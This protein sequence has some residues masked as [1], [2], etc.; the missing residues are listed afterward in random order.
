[1]KLLKENFG[2]ES[3]IGLKDWTF[4]KRIWQSGLLALGIH[5]MKL[6]C[7]ST[8]L[9]D[10]IRSTYNRYFFCEGQGTVHIQQPFVKLSPKKTHSK[11][12]EVTVKVWSSQRALSEIFIERRDGVHTRR[13]TTGSVERDF[14]WK[15]RTWQPSHC[16]WSAVLMTCYW[17]QLTWTW[18]WHP[19]RQCPSPMV[20]HHDLVFHQLPH[21]HHQSCERTV[22]AVTVLLWRCSP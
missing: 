20:I 18:P 14:H 10:Q 4:P 13:L 15:T 3:N 21:H 17:H 8:Y 11:L 2:Q 6:V 16:R 19:R 1:M 12:V 7:H 22:F 5:K 9:S